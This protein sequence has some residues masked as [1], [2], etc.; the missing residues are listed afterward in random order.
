MQSNLGIIYQLSYYYNWSTAVCLCVLSVSM[1]YTLQRDVADSAAA[2]RARVIGCIFN[3][4]MMHLF[5]IVL[6]KAVHVYQLTAAS[7]A[8]SY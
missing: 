2:V 3:R 5:A 4:L 1:C 7:F 8:R 6:D